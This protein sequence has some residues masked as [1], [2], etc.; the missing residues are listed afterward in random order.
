M[1]LRDCLDDSWHSFLDLPGWLFPW[2]ALALVGAGV[3]TLG[4]VAWAVY[5]VAGWLPG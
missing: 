3:L 1:K 5:R 4:V 2:A